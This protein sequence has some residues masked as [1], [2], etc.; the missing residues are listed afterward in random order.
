VLPHKPPPTRSPVPPQGRPA[1]LH[2]N[3][4]YSVKC[5]VTPQNM[6]PRTLRSIPSTLPPNTSPIQA[7][8]LRHHPPPLLPS[9]SLPSQTPSR[10]RRKNMFVVLASVDSPPAVT[11]LAIF[12]FTQVNETTDAPS[13]AARLDVPDKTTSS[14]SKYR[15]PSY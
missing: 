4:H 7:S 1:T 10:A 14:N 2:T 11:L 12:A 3:I 15:C 6:T 9:T 8:P 13:P 5:P